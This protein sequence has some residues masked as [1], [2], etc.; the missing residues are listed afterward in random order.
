M[1]VHAVT[2][3]GHLKITSETGASRPLVLLAVIFSLAAMALAFVYVS[4]E[5][6]QVIGILIG[7][8]VVAASTGILCQ[9][10][11]ESRVKSRIE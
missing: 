1:F 5:S 10:M 7:F 8:I 4:K 3:V 2:H 11:E 9:K 6:N